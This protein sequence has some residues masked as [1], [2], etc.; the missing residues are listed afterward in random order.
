MR[1]YSDLNLDDVLGQGIL[2]LHFVTNRH[3]KEIT[4]DRKLEG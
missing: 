1:K 4:K 3:H 2:K